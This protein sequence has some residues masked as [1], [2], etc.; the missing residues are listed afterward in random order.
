MES[1]SALQVLRWSFLL[2]WLVE[3]ASAIIFW[4]GFIS[5]VVIPWLLKN[6]GVKLVFD[7]LLSIKLNIA[8]LLG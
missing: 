3:K 1:I 6:L 8:N 7:K 2:V 5:G 4:F